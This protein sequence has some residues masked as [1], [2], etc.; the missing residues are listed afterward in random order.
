MPTETNKN[1]VKLNDGV[2]VNASYIL[3]IRRLT[4]AD[5]SS[6]DL[7][8]RRMLDSV[9]KGTGLCTDKLYTSDLQGGYKPRNGV[10]IDKDLPELCLVVL[11]GG[12][13]LFVKASLCRQITGIQEI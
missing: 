4:P 3:K 9:L 5:L 11:Q 13:E 1:F 12:G 10:T 2:V 6:L 8:K 7:Y